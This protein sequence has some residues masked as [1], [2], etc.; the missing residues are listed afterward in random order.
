GRYPALNRARRQ[1]REAFFSRPTVIDFGDPGFPHRLNPLEPAAWLSTAEQ[2]E[3]FAASIER[4]LGG[5]LSEMRALHL[6]LVALASVLID[7]GGATVADMAELAMLPTDSLQ[8]FLRR[9]ERT[10]AEGRLGVPVRPDLARLYMGRF[11]AQTSG[12]ER[13]EQC[14]S[15]LRALAILLSDPVA[16][17]FL[18]SPTGNVDLRATMDEGRP[19]LVSLPPDN[20]HTQA[21]I[22]SLLLSR[23]SALAMR[24]SSE[25]A[26]AG[27]VP[28]VHLTIDE[29]QRCFTKEMAADLAVLRNKAVSV[30]LA[31]QS[32]Q[33]PGF[34][35][36]EGRT[37]LESV[38]DNCST[39]IVMRT[40][41]RDADELAGP[42]FQPRGLMEKLRREEVSFS[43]SEQ[44]SASEQFS[45]S[46]TVGRSHASGSSWSETDSRT[47]TR[48]EGSS[49]TVGR[50]TTETE[51][52]STTKSRG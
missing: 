15:T 5:K 3:A 17:R 18:S 34:E 33:Q 20:L 7:T 37:M 43:S 22:S 30:V 50:Q 26:A 14:A 28:Q 6:L 35:G 9:A 27:R 11:F 1:E 13:R 10:R 29:F 42:I 21:G 38:R 16:S 46:Q 25:D 44:F 36:L 19:L 49:V 39:H 2:A 45:E 8:E 32:S 47:R 48:A 41:H 4:M 12:R 24:R 40:G 31:H 52:A 51:A 23:I